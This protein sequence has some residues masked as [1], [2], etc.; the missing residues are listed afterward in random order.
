MT[1]QRIAKW[2]RW[3]EGPIKGDVLTMHLHRATWLEASGI[4]A[5]NGSLP[6]SYWWEFM[7]DTYAVSQS[8]AVRRQVDVHRDVAS[9]GKLISEIASDPTIISREFWLSLWDDP[10]LGQLSQ[11]GWDKQYAGSVGIHL[12][13][14]IPAADAEKLAELSRDVKRFVDKHI[15]HSEAYAEPPKITL[16]LADLHE[17]IDVVGSMFRKY[18]NLITGASY[19]SLTPVIQHRWQAA[20]EVPWIKPGSR[21][22]PRD[23]GET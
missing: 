12:D 17:T 16:T 14:A 9:L 22:R 4:I 5:E 18:Y 13:P 6:D 1:D 2:T 20:F 21:P 3:I 7:R 11:S 10:D 23:S 15:A 19:M 8:V